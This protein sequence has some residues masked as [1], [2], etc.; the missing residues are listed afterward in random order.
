M[1]QQR[2]SRYS[3]K[4]ARR[5]RRQQ[6]RAPGLVDQ[7]VYHRLPWGGAEKRQLREGGLAV[8]AQRRGVDEQRALRKGAAQRCAVEG[9]RLHPVGAQGGQ[10][11]RRLRAAGG[12]ENMGRARSRQRAAHRRRRAA[13][14]QQQH[15][16][17]RR[18]KAPAAQAVHQPHAVG[19]VP[20][21][22]SVT[23]ADGVHRAAVGGEAVHLVQQGHDGLLVGHGDVAARPRA[24][25]RR[26]HELRQRGGGHGVQLVGIGCA[27]LGDHGAVEQRRK[28]VPHRVADNAEPSRRHS[29]PSPA[30]APSFARA[31]RKSI[32]SR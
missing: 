21:G 15:R 20:H 7:I 6:S 5:C 29:V 16:P 8:H 28:A 27:G 25:L 24:I 3:R 10:R 2:R 30:P 4:A 26:C 22:A 9:H 11:S 19:I 17:S 23:E 32:A 12:D 18:V 13:C 31:S 14:A 1:Q